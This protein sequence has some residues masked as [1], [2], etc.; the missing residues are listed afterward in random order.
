[1]EASEEAR[2]KLKDKIAIKIKNVGLNY[3]PFNSILLDHKSTHG[4]FLY[5]VN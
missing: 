4:C 3:F 1:L 5:H 2:R